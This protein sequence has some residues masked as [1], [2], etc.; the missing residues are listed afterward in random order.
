M[1]PDLSLPYWLAALA[2]LALVG[3]ALAVSVLARGIGRERRRTTELLAQAA[4]DAEELRRQLVR[5][6]EQ[7]GAQTARAERATRAAAD[8]G[9][10][11]AVADDREYLITA[12]GQEH[13]EPAP[14]VPAPVFADIVLR[15]SVIKTAALA[16]GLR[17]A[18]SPEVRNRIRFEMRREVKRARK[19][20]RTDLR[21]AR[22][23][24][25]A[26]QRAGMEP[27]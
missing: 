13:R 15:E 23:E 3:L 19:Q 5:I 10:V 17:R 18:L 2:L 11:P 24:Y 8:G 1:T 20:R 25:E 14:V 9:Q 22:R 21:Q 26:R 12:L 27:T 7:L 16:A 6:E 4:A